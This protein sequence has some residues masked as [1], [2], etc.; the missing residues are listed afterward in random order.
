M[1]PA[2][3]RTDI[4]V[5]IMDRSKNYFFYTEKPDKMEI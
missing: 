2:P 4:L 5:K 3:Y 1:N